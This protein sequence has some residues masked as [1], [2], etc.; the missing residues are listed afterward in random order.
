MT[1]IMNITIIVIKSNSFFESSLRSFLSLFSICR[2]SFFCSY[3][4]GSFL[5]LS[6]IQ[7]FEV[8]K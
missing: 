1:T 7:I 5:M 3:L 6:N 8:S 2:L 4:Y